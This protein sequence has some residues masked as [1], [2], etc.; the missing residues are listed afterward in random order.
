[1]QEIINQLSEIASEAD[2]T[3][4]ERAQRLETIADDSGATPA[5]LY[6]IEQDLR[7]LGWTVVSRNE[8]KTDDLEAVMKQIA[9]FAGIDPQGISTETLI[10]LISQYA[11]EKPEAT[12]HAV[13]TLDDVLSRRGLY[14]ELDVEVSVSRSYQ[15]PLIDD[16]GDE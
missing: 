13:A 3:P 14:D 11:L 12:A 7:G 4:E 15:E 10:R 9:L 5:T 16:E 1:M 6:E 8:Q 2:E